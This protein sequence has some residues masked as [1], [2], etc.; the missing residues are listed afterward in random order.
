M[1]M[2]DLDGTSALVT[3]AAHGIGAGIAEVLARE[4]AH[5]AITDIDAQAASQTAE[6]IVESG[7][8]ALALSHDVTDASSCRE[9]VEQ[10][11]ETFGRIDVLV[12]NAGISQRKPFKEID[13][14][15]WDRMIDINL[16]GVYLMVQAVLDE[17]MQRRSGRIIN[18]A[19]LIGKAGALPLFTHYVASKFA[20]VGLTQSLA[21]ELAPHNILVNAVCPG[22]VRTPL[23][24]PLLASNAKEQGISVEEAW[25]Q[26]TAPIPLGRP[27]DPED[28][29]Y[30]VAFL[31]SERARNIT[32]E[33]I[34]VNGGQLMD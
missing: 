20:V 6:R 4:G 10:T 15:A 2:G 31:A 24:E 11:R 33:S 13:E 34:N 23:W 12:N 29:G 25:K 1:E 28:I 21:A 27:Q 22:V 16:K 14:A 5:V 3:G 19:S 17:M 7:G 26:A 9:V 30:A 32:G 18:T 8:Q